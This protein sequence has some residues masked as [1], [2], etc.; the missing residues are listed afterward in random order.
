VAL[1]IQQA[2]EHAVAFAKAALGEA[3]TQGLRLEEVETS[4]IGGDEVWLIT[5]GMY[6]PEDLHPI[7]SLLTDVFQDRRRRE[8]KTFAIRKRD[9]EVL[10]MRIRELANA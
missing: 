2:A 1:T 7:G 6:A 5:L 3:R 4:E 9:G 10:W 8:Y